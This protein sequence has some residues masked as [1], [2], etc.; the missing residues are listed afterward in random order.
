MARIH[1]K[2]WDNFFEE[3]PFTSSHNGNDLAADLYEENNCVIIEMNVAG[4]NPD[5]IDID[6]ENNYVKIAGSREE[7]R[8]EEETDYYYKEI[9]RGAFERVIPLPTAI[10][11]TAEVAHGVLKINLP[12]LKSGEK[13]KIAVKKK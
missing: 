11:P 12:K 8:K 3:L 13:S 7:K 6:V 1:W 4:I 9:R 5:K 10:D 2:P